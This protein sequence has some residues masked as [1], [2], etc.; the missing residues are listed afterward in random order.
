MNISLRKYPYPYQAMLAVC[1]DLDETPNKEIYFETARYLNTTE[2]TILGKGVGLEVGNSIYFDMPEN[3]FSYTNT[4]NDGRKKIHYLIDSGHIDC[5]HSF[6]DFVNSRE[7]IKLCWAELQKGQRKLEV[8]IDHAQ[9]PTNLD[10]DIMQGEGAV[11]GADAFHTDLTVKTGGLSFIWKGRVT[12]IASQNVK[13]N[14][15][16]LF[17]IKEPYKSGK[18]IL[19][20]FIKGWFARLGS[21]KYAMHKD[22]HVLRKTQLLDGTPVQEFMRC[23]PSWGGVSVFDSA[24]GIHNVLTESVLNTLLKNKGCSVLYSHLGK[25]FS[26]EQ[27]FK[28]C[29]RDAFELLAAYQKNKLILTAT[30]RRLLGYCRTV[31]E[32]SFMVKSADDKEQIHLSTTYKGQDLY[33]LTWY[34]DDPE[35]VAL[36]INGKYYSN[37]QINPADNSGRK[38]VSIAWPPLVFPDIKSPV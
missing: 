24:R 32:L 38:S 23:N 11:A 10:D 3:Q 18:T 34:A 17:N 36:Y 20:E 27:A 29:T 16:S 33:G 25:V 35:K 7:R 2:Q 13:R 5:L 14:Y 21:V 30:T 9:A 15:R 22:N 28:Q 1:S 6:G 37:L 26:G 8:W 19:I 12:S 31:E 4:D